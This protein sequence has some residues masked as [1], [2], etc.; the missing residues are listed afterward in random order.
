MM[1]STGNCTKPLKSDFQGMIYPK[2]FYF[3]DIM[4]YNFSGYSWEVVD[5]EHEN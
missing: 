2:A 5:E 3:N 1:V 4:A